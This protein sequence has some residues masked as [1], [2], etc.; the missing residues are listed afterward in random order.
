MVSF[1]ILSTV[2]A[3]ADEKSFDSGKVVGVF[4]ADEHVE[5]VLVVAKLV[6]EVDTVSTSRFHT[7]R[8]NTESS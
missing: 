7:A 5:A 4:E 6:N 3:C 1:T 2:S 8:N